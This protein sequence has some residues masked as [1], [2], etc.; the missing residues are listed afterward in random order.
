MKPLVVLGLMTGLLAGFAVCIVSDRQ[1]LQLPGSEG[2]PE[3]VRPPLDLPL[4]G[5]LR[6][7]VSDRKSPATVPPLSR[8]DD[9]KSHQLQL[10]IERALVSIDDVERDRAYTQLL[11]ALSAIDPVA[12]ERLVECC[13]AGQVREQLLRH[14]ALVWSAANLDGAIRWVTAMKDD[15]ERDIAAT[16]IVSQVAQADPGHAIEVSDLFGIGRKDGTVEHIAQL[17]A[18]E[19]LKASLRWVEAQPPGAQRDQLLARIIDVQAQ[20][21]PADAAST[22]LNQISPGP[23]QDAA[24]ASV[25]RQWSIQDADAAAAWV[26]ELPNGHD[27]Q[28]RLLRVGY[29]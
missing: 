7:A 23:M 26:E 19:N 24:V 21:A 13:P 12:V 6:A 17:W 20:T 2:V 3:A 29:Q 1:P 27:L 16:E 8:S 5:N 4:P 25:V 10:E 22:V 15:G 9:E 28:M 11:P 14:A 18:A